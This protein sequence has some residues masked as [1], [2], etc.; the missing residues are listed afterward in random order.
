MLTL[1]K[2]AYIGETDLDAIA[3]SQVASLKNS[4]KPGFSPLKNLNSVRQN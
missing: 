3:L 1:T 4:K 2:R